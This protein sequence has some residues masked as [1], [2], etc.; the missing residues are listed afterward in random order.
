MY[1]IYLLYLGLISLMACPVDKAIG[2]TAVSIIVIIVIWVLIGVTVSLLTAGF[3]TGMHMTSRSHN[4]VAERVIEANLAKHGV[5][6][7]VDS[8][9]GKVSIQTK[10]G[11]ATYAG[12]QGTTVPD[13]FPK[14]VYVPAGATVLAT[15]PMPNGCNLT[16]ESSD[17]AATVAQAFKTQMTAAGWQETMT[18]NQGGGMILGYKKA[19][20]TA[21]IIISGD[22]KKTQIHL[23]VVAEKNAE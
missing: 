21:S 19:A 12:G 8:A 11:T 7:Q 22:S 10:D 9:A 13:S 23:T 14:D 20:R 18:M 6:A 16:L 17:S 2:Y 4:S 15:V 3:H 5:K 1:G